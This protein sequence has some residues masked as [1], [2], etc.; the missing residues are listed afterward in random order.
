MLGVSRQSLWN[1]LELQH[2]RPPNDLLRKLAF[3]LG[4]PVDGSQAPKLAEVLRLWREAKVR[5]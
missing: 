4:K 1:L 2:K 3:A 5:A